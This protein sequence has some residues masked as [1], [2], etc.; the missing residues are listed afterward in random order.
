MVKNNIED[1]YVWYIYRAE[2][3]YLIYNIKNN[4]E[5]FKIPIQINDSKYIAATYEDKDILEE[6]TMCSLMN[7]SIPDNLKFTELIKWPSKKFIEADNKVEL[8]TFSGTME[9][10][11]GRDFV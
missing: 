9:D 1:A 11:F 4:K 3:K 8:I 2:Y 5:N 7:N 10:K 6:V